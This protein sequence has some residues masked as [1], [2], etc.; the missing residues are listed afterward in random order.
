MP[1]LSCPPCIPA[2]LELHSVAEKG[3]TVGKEL[4]GEEVIKCVAHDE[5]F[6]DRILD[7]WVSD[8]LDLAA[9]HI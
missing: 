3:P 6:V 2:N 9:C 7:T 8:N 1:I 4:W 5:E